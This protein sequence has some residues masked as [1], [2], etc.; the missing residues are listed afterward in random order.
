M[1]LRLRLKSTT[2]TR[3]TLRLFLIS[4]SRNLLTPVPIPVTKDLR[5]GLLGLELRLVRAILNY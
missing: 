2:G 5:V 3:A 1:I 4:I